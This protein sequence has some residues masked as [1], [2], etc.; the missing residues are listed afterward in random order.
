MANIIDNLFDETEQFFAEWTKHESEIIAALEHIN[1]ASLA[2]NAPEH[3]R[4]V[5]RLRDWNQFVQFTIRQSFMYLNSPEVLKKRLNF[6][7][8]ITSIEVS[9]PLVLISLS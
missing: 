9:F 5:K 7:Q 2:S 1:L 8:A 4:V 3:Y 6:V